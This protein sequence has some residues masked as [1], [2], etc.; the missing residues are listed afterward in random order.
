M[1]E[2]EI[3]NI[4]AAIDKELKL[5]NMSKAQKEA[6][7]ERII[8]KARENDVKSIRGLETLTNKG[9]RVEIM[10]GNGLRINADALT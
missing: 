9:G 5:S 7:R 1:T 6:I 2:Q 4:G 8:S 3:K 10:L